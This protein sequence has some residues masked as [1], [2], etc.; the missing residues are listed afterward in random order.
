MWS[1]APISLGMT[2]GRLAA[3]VPSATPVVWIRGVLAIT[4]YTV[5]PGTNPVTV[6]S[7]ALPGVL[8][9]AAT[10]SSSGKD[11]IVSRVGTCKGIEVASGGS[12]ASG[13]VDGSTEGTSGAVVVGAS[14]VVVGRGGGITIMRGM[15]G[16]DADDDAE[17]PP[18]LVAVTTK[19]CAVSLRSPRTSHRRGPVF[20]VQLRP[21]G[22]A[23]TVWVVIGASLTDGA[24]HDTV[25]VESP[26]AALTVVGAVGGR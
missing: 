15:T 5:S 14:V 22:D 11:R 20:Q 4:Q 21:P 7:M 16:V 8:Y 17:V 18:R 10:P 1:P 6:N 9:R 23:V 12:V 24:N 25:A 2:P 13:S 26:G 3:P 19:V